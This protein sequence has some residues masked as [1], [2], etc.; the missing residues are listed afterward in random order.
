LVRAKRSLTTHWG[1]A[2]GQPVED[3]VLKRRIRRGEG[4]AGG[5]GGR[6]ECAQQAQ[7]VGA[8]RQRR[9]PA[10]ERSERRRDDVQQHRGAKGLRALGAR[11]KLVS[12]RAGNAQV[13]P[14][15]K[16]AA[17]AAR[18]SAGQLVGVLGGD[19]ERRV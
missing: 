15:A 16:Q 3:A 6:V 19:G 1:A 5:Q 9:E 17:L 4:K 2:L 11:L 12:A 10:I 18:Q 7:A 14:R 8:E 13:E